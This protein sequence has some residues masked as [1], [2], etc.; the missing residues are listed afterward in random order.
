V[1]VHASHEALTLGSYG[2][3]L[4]ETMT[5]WMPG[6]RR[7]SVTMSRAVKMTFEE[8]SACYH[9]Q[10]AKLRTACGPCDICSTEDNR[11]TVQPRIDRNFCKLVIVETILALGLA[12]SKMLVAPDLL[13]KRAGIE[14]F[15]DRQVRKR[16]QTKDPALTKLEHFVI[17]YGNELLP[18]NVT[19]VGSLRRNIR[20]I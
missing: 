2:A 9:E 12:L 13:P 6:L 3:G 16:I 10:L 18:M 1:S 7:S 8:A 14:D 15:Y 11:S 19:Q 5:N 20:S 17:V 4:V